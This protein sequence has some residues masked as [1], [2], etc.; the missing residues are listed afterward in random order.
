[1]V[2]VAH[3]SDGGGSIRIPSSNCG[4]F[5]LQ[6]SR[7]RML[8]NRPSTWAIDISVSHVVSRSVRD[9]TA[10]FAATERTDSDAPFR[11]VGLVSPALSRSLKGRPRHEHRR[12][13]CA[14][15]PEVRAAVESAARAAGE[16]W[17]T[18]WN[19]RPLPMDWRPLR[20][21]LH[22]PAGQRRGRTGRRHRSGPRPQARR[23]GAGALQPGHGCRAGR[24]ASAGCPCPP[25][26]PA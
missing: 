12:R 25:P 5:G 4:L 9:S 2:P 15:D 24:P 1:M 10:L 3:A 6:P 7:G 11:P 26:S 8:P 19:P 21:R 13:S 23:R 18:R 14:A 22:G 20:P 17:A 16:A